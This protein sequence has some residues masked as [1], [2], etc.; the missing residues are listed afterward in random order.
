MVMI[1]SCC[2]RAASLGGSVSTVVST[3][4]QQ[5]QLIP[6]DK[7]D[8]SEIKDLLICF[9]FIVKNLSEGEAGFLGSVYTKRQRQ[10]CN[11]AS[12]T[13]LIENN[14]GDLKHVRPATVYC[15][16]QCQFNHH[17]QLYSIMAHLHCWTWT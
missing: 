4:Q 17:R 5:Q 3:Q 6:F 1:Y 16:W 11:N 9:L 12:D 8:P 13:V 7:L 10:L 14:G 15:V 2:F